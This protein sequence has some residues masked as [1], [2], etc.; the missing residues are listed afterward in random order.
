VLRAPRPVL[1]AAPPPA[2]SDVDADLEAD[3]QPDADP[4]LDSDAPGE[5]VLMQASRLLAR[6]LRRFWSLRP[7]PGVLAASDKPAVQPNQ[8]MLPPERNTADFYTDLVPNSL[9]LW[10]RLAEDLLA[11]Q[12][13]S[14]INRLFPHL[15]N[16]LLFCTFGFIAALLTF[17]TYPFQPQRFLMMSV[18]LFILG[19][20]P[21]TLYVLVQMNRD[22]VLS[23]LGKS[24]PGR[25]TFDRRF[26]SQI[27]LYGVL[28]LLSLVAT[29][30]PGVRGVAFSWLE[31]LLKTLK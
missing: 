9:H 3:D 31:S 17:S 18:W 10:L 25:V 4:G 29:Q 1:R 30:F 5:Q 21:I 14:Y 24:E 27:V 7:L 13:V 2:S 16:A 20:L 12:V 15:R 23:R 26:M 19:T 28:P 6:I 22:D 8:A 11:V